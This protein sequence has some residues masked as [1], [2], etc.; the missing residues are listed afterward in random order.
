MQE[1]FKVAIFMAWA[2]NVAAAPAPQ[3]WPGGAH[4]KYFGPTDNPL[5]PE[6]IRL[7]EEWHE[8]SKHNVSTTQVETAT[9]GGKDLHVISLTDAQLDAITAADESPTDTD[10]MRYLPGTLASP[11]KREDM[12]NPAEK[13]HLAHIYKVMKANFSHDEIYS[14]F[15][16]S[17][18]EPIRLTD[19]AVDGAITAHKAFATAQKKV[20]RKARPKK[21]ATHPKC[22]S[23]LAEYWLNPALDYSDI[24]Q[25]DHIDTSLYSF[26]DKP[27]SK[28]HE[29]K[30]DSHKTLVKTE[31]RSIEEPRHTR[32]RDLPQCYNRF[33]FYNP[34]LYEHS[35][36]L[37]S[38]PPCPPPYWP[39]EL[40]RRRDR[41]G[42]STHSKDEKPARL[43]DEAADD[44]STAHK[45]FAT[46]QKKF[47]RKARPK[48]KAIYPKCFESTAKYRLN[49]DLDYSDIPTCGIDA[50][51][52]SSNDKLTPRIHETMEDSHKTFVKTEKR[53][54]EKAQL[55][56][57]YDL[58]KCYDYH[59]RYAIGNYK[60]PEL[61]SSLP[62]CHH[63]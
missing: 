33:A 17:D 48:K 43:S 40:A 50:S 15:H 46:A 58:P 45:A 16:S 34:S 22:F 63:E 56:R 49:P 10:S 28:T 30:E 4:P 44:A 32:Y 55:E 6:E 18:G 59:A 9:H 27:K 31:K 5:T 54:I 52:Y 20:A 38:L 11:V 47:A 26:N 62:P 13:E 41:R 8:F 36:L 2:W 60:H 61:F 51:L 24:P 25:C 19:E 23:S 39:K 53:S 35:E 29:T 7:N 42:T 12:Q 1:I 3:R 57:Y 21:K 37:T 14:L